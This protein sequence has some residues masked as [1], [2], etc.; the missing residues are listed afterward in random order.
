MC[1]KRN[2][3]SL[4]A[5][6]WNSHKF[7]HQRK[8]AT[9]RT[10]FIMWT[11]LGHLPACMRLSVRACLNVCLL[12]LTAGMGQ[13]FTIWLSISTLKQEVLSAAVLVDRM[14]H[15]S[16]VQL[17]CSISNRSTSIA[18]H[19]VLSTHR[20][21][22]DLFSSPRCVIILVNERSCGFIH[23]T[24]MMCSPLFH[25]ASTYEKHKCTLHF[26]WTLQTGHTPLFKKSLFESKF[27]RLPT[28]ISIAS[29]NN[30]CHMAMNYNRYTIIHFHKVHWHVERYSALLKGFQRIGNEKQFEHEPTIGPLAI[31]TLVIHK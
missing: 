8:F 5:V 1:L 23:S 22:F 9:W 7:V 25:A 13:A 10:N 4:S 12:F 24:H 30:Q 3:I 2:E 27:F 31:L 28:V 17:W 21:E 16:F 29:R 18:C 15:R 14:T 11:K 19:K 26:S 6:E 20:T